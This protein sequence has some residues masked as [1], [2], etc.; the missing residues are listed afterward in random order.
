MTISAVLAS[1]ADCE[2]FDQIAVATEWE[3]ATQ[4]PCRKWMNN[5][6]LCA[7][8]SKYTNVKT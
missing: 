4:M 2:S 7:D 1:Y 6:A 5:L 3:K 8:V